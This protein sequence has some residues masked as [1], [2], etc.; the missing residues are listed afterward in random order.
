LAQDSLRD[1]D[2]MFDQLVACAGA[3]ALASSGSKTLT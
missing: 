2:V 1:A 3:D